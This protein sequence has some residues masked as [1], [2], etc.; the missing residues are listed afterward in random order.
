MYQI[1]IW[2]TGKEYNRYINCVQLLIERQEICVVAVTSND[3][4]IVDRID[5]FRFVEKHNIY[6]IYF[7]YCILAVENIKCVID[8]AIGLGI[9]SHQIIPIRALSIPGFRF[10]EYLKLKKNTPSIFS[11]NCWA[12][13]CYHRLGLEFLS[14][15][16][17][18]FVEEG[19]FNKFIRNLKEYM[20]LP[21]SFEEER[22]DLN[23]NKIYP[24]GRLGDI[25]LHFNHY[26]SFDDA[27]LFWNRR[28]EKINWDN[29]LIV[30]Y[31]ESYQ[32]V[33][34]F[35]SL[36]YNNKII[37]TNVDAK[38]A[39]SLHIRDNKKELWE[40]TNDIA[41]GR[42]NII[43]MIRLLNHEKDFLRV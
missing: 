11:I 10:S 34:E 22:V 31:S 12:G 43:D 4:D 24:V 38:T 5:G 37:F 16:I 15:T 9:E 39:T 25:L 30:S 35:D 3:N 28:K 1:L 27:V 7:D 36:P 17:N 20:S 32:T 14:P 33:V 13:L 19:H 29:I 26:D 40:I 41:S 2:G 21:I 6:S 23:S 8:E 42:K 18:M